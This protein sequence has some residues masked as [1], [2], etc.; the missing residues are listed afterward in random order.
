MEH[1]DITADES[2][3]HCGDDRRCDRLRASLPR[4]LDR[5]VARIRELPHS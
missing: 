2:R 4:L 1:D 3:S 5:I